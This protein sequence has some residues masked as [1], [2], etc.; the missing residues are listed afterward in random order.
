MDHGLEA[1]IGF[2]SAHGDALEFLEFAEEVFD[3]VAPLVH[4]GVERDGS[5]A[6]RVLRDDDFCTPLVEIGDDIVAVES[7]VSEQCA[8]LDAVD[9]WSN[10]NRVEAV[11]GH[12]AEADKVAQRIGQ[13][14]DLGRH[15]PF[16]TTNG[17]ALSPPFAPWPCR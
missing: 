15:A 10:A 14:Q 2:A 5:G 17:L 8:E 13:S 11:T 16:G 12:Q 1:A 6:S 3:E 4:F 9:E 7:L